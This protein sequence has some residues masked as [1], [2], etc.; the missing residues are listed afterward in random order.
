MTNVLI[1][2]PSSPKFSGMGRVIIYKLNEN[3]KKKGSR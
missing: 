1:K 2:L 3:I